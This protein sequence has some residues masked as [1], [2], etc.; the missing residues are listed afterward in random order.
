MQPAGR[1]A[2]LAGCLLLARGLLA[3]GTGDFDAD[4][5]ATVRE[6]QARTVPPGAKLVAELPITRDTWSSQATW[7]VEVS[8]SWDEYMQRVRD[9]L[10]GFTALPGASGTVQFSRTLPNDSHTLRVEVLSA[11]PLLRV[12]VT[13]DALA[14]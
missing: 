9:R 7:E 3:C 5:R 4:L 6:L 10:A 13:F 1:A 14:S 2:V 12:R 11:R 8:T